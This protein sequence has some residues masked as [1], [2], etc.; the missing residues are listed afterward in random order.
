VPPRPPAR[1]IPFVSR[2][3]ARAGGSVDGT[4]EGVAPR[5]DARL[6]E[7]GVRLPTARAPALDD[8]EIVAGVRAGDAKAAE[9][10]HD[11]VR[12]LVERAVVRLLG[13]RDRD[14]EDLVQ[15]SLIEIMRSLR[16]YRGECSLDTWASRVTAHTVFK[17]IRRRRGDRAL[18]DPYADVA[19]YDVSSL[20]PDRALVMRSTLQRVRAHLAEMDPLKAWTVVLHDVN[21][22]DLSEIAEITEVTVTAAQSRLVRG[23]KDLHARVEADPELREVLDQMRGR[24]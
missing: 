17:A 21:G 19:R 10:L 8:N 6:T 1:V 4:D 9:A 18:V 11:R 20:D 24:R 14:H 22:Y 16:G 2:E 12:T 5:H 15:V 23:R 7:S 3:E 13:R